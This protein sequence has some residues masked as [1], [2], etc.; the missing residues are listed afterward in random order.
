MAPPQLVAPSRGVHDHNGASNQSPDIDAARALISM[1][2]R[3]QPA[4]AQSAATAQRLT[5]IGSANE[6]CRARD[7]ESI[8]D[9]GHPDA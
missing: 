4:A 2:Y 5:S 1:R 3:G 9:E 8:D 7:N 6:T